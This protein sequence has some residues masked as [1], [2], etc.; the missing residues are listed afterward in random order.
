MLVKQCNIILILQM[1]KLRHTDTF[2]SKTTKEICGKTS[3]G[4]WSLESA[5]IRVWGGPQSSLALTCLWQSRSWRTRKQKVSVSISW[6][7]KLQSENK[8]KC[9]EIF[10]FFFSNFNYF[11]TP[12]VSF[13]PRRIIC[14]TLLFTQICI[15][16]NLE[17]LIRRKSVD[18]QNLRLMSP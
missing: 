8:Y 13:T 17:G 6:A 9:N 1:E 14:Y 7:T 2:P 11:L 18:H 12:E 5:C 15:V 3:T 10:W 16:S 4:S